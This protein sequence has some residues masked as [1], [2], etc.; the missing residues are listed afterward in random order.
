MDDPVQLPALI[1]F[2]PSLYKIAK[3]SYQGF[4]EVQ[5]MLGKSNLGNKI[6]FQ[7]FRRVKLNIQLKNLTEFQT[8]SIVITSQPL[9][10]NLTNFLLG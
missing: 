9:L 1:D 5:Q 10:C 6:S 4:S 7:T 8:V 2:H 3:L